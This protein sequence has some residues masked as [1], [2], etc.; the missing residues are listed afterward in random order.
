MILSARIVFQG[1]GFVHRAGSN[2]PFL[3]LRRS[4]YLI[5][6]KVAGYR[7][8]VQILYDFLAGS[9]LGLMVITE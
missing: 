1:Q 5:L 3:G 9:N 6:G 7:M 8:F 4:F 2:K